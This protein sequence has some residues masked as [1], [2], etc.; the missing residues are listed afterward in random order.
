[1]KTLFIPIFFSLLSGCASYSAQTP[2][3]DARFGNAVREAKLN[4]T[5]NPEAGK[6]LIRQLVW[7]AFRPEKLSF[8]I[9]ELSRHRRR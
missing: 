4:M 2:N 6:N 3:Y 5:I 1:M 9:K 7:M 8:F